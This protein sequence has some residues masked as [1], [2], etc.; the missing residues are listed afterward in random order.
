MKD[1]MIEVEG[2]VEE[3][4]PN[5]MFRVNIGHKKILMCSISGKLRQ[6]YIRILRGDR[7]TVQVSPYD[8]TK[9]RIVWRHK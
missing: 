1:D 5:T 8:L 6:H 4:C 2:V 9:G 3:V 7:V